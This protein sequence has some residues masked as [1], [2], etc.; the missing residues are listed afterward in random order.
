MKR[1]AYLAEKP[2]SINNL[3]IVEQDLKPPAEN[4]VTVEVK[5]IGLN[6]ADIFTVL[7]LYKAAPGRNIIPGIEFSGVVFDTGKNVKNFQSG[8]RIYGST[9]FGAY[10]SHLNIDSFYILKIPDKWNYEQAAASIVQPLTAYYALVVLAQVQKGNT[11]LIHSAAGG[12]GLNANRIAKKLGAFTIGTVGNPDKLPVLDNEGYD[13]KIVRG[14]NLRKDILAALGDREL[15]VVLDSVGSKVF[16]T[17]FDLLAPMGRIIVY[18]AGAYSTGNASSDLFKL[19]FTYLTRPKIDPL[20][21]IE[22]NR[23]VM[24]FNLIWLYEKG[25]LLKG[26]LNELQKLE[27]GEPFISEIFGFDDLKSAMLRLKS[28]KTTGKII[29][30]I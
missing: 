14:K 11:V 17:S 21:M 4:E 28:G 9:K 16:K 26:Y 5:A 8:D 6:Y 3:K 27:L 25:E 7:G 1:R 12:V 20:T 13:R 15:N 23:A 10:A 2:G 24:A 29:V 19:A 18:G 22:Q 30:K